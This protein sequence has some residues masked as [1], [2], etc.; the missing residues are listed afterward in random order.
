[1]SPEYLLETRPFFRRPD[2]RTPPFPSQDRR[3]ESSLGGLHSAPRQGI[4]APV[5]FDSNE[6]ALSLSLFPSQ[7]VPTFPKTEGSAIMTQRTSTGGT[8]FPSLCYGDPQQPDAVSSPSLRRH[9]FFFLDKNVSDKPGDCSVFP[10]LHSFLLPR[11]PLFGYLFSSPHMFLVLRD[12]PPTNCGS[13]FLPFRLA[14]GCSFCF[15]MKPLYFPLFWLFPQPPTEKQLG[16]F[17]LAP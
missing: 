3:K 4:A 11:S 15:L 14:L 16:T 6:P 5:S 7:S 9:F 2:F 17:F 8:P 10:F 1:V 12:F 13:P